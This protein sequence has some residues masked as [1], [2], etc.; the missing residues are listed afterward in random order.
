[1]QEEIGKFDNFAKNRK[2]LY[3]KIDA[4]PLEESER[5]RNNSLKD[6]EFEKDY[7]D[8]YKAKIEAQ[9]L[10]IANKKSKLLNRILEFRKI[11]NL[12]RNLG[13]Q[14]DILKNHEK[15]LTEK[16][17][18]VSAYDYLVEEE[19]KMADL[20]GEAL[21]D[22]A[23]WDENKK[24]ELLK[25][26]D[27]RDIIKLAGKHGVFFVHDIVDAE[28]KPSANNR[29]IDTKNLDFNNQLDIL[30]GLDPTISISTLHK[31]SKQRTFG[32]GSWGVFLSGGKVL[33]GDKSDAGTVAHGLR[34]R[35]FYSKSN[36]TTEAIENAILRK[37]FSDENENAMESTNY[38]E[39]IVENPEIA[40]VYVKWD[41]EMPPLVDDSEI[42]L[43]NENGIRYDAWWQKIA[44]V[45]KRGMPI[46]VLNRENNTTRLLY[47]IDIKNK[48]FKVTSEY[49]PNNL[50]DM[51]GV[52]K[53]HLGKEEKRKAT[54][55]VF[56][57]AVGLIPEDERSIYTPDGTEEDGRGLYDVN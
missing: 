25:E 46:F 31:G 24:N 7:I 54:M 23:Q 39:L 38:N 9:R 4:N 1:M 48:S 34:D 14:E 51:P 40:G 47:D 33:G 3:G 52:Y 43:K 19:K 22:N 44:D 35:E 56:D 11:K 10:E 16:N 12:E 8:E 27:G 29:V 21:Q 20:M 32:K 26:R 18:L 5:D 17:D 50:T 57:K 55:R 45:M 37:S 28:W 49:D 36:T 53:Q 30:H 2:E 6:V 15:K 42:Y 13:I 41:N